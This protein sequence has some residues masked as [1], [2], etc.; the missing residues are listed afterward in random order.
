MLRKEGYVGRN[1][2]QGA[3]YNEWSPIDEKGSE[4]LRPSMTTLGEM[5]VTTIPINAIG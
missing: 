4:Q 3:Q 2:G 5:I 1:D